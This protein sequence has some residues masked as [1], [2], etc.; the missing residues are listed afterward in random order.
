MVVTGLK[1]TVNVQNVPATV[2]VVSGEQLREQNITHLNDFSRLVSGLQVRRSSNENTW[3]QVRGLGTSTATRVIDT[4]VGQFINDAYMGHNF[5]FQSSLFDMDHMELLKGTQAALLGKNTSLG[6]V[7]VTT[8]EPG[9]DYSSNLTLSHDFEYGSNLADVGVDVPISDTFSVR[10]AGQYNYQGGWIHN[11]IT[12]DEGPEETSTG[13]RITAVWRPNDSFDL[14]FMY[15][16]SRRSRTGTSVENVNDFGAILTGTPRYAGETAGNWQNDASPWFGPETMRVD[17]NVQTLTANYHMN[18]GIKLTSIT[19]HVGATSDWRTD[20]GWIWWPVAGDFEHSREEIWS[21][22]FR[23]TSPDEGRITYQGGLYLARDRY[24]VNT[25]YQGYGNY[26]S[27]VYTQIGGANPPPTTAGTPLSQQLSRVQPTITNDLIDLYHSTTDTAALYGQATY[28]FT[29]QWSVTG[30]LRWTYEKREADFLRQFLIGNPAL[31]PG[32]PGATPAN[33]ST[34]PGCLITGSVPWAFGGQVPSCTVQG[35]SWAG[36][37]NK[38][39]PFRSYYD[40]SISLNYQLND[41]V[42]LYASWSKGTKG[43]NLLSG[44]SGSPSTFFEPEVAYTTELGVKSQFRDLPFGDIR[45]NASIFHVELDKLQVSSFSPGSFTGGN[46]NV[47]S[48][49]V[50]LDVTWRP[51]IN[52]L[53]LGTTLEYVDAQNLNSPNDATPVGNGTPPAGTPE[54]SGY[55]WAEYTQALSDN[56][57]FSILPSVNFRS[58]MY[59]REWVRPG[60]NPCN[61]GATGF[62]N[63]CLFPVGPSYAEINLRL[64]LRND[65]HGWELALV[66]KNLNDEYVLNQVVPGVPGMMVQGASEP[67]RTIALQFSISR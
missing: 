61:P 60:A 54:W 1:R 16:A 10:L 62:T 13:G 25:E 66:G 63:S 40:G 57:S 26:A 56:Y 23:I 14:H 19:A 41:D 12:N 8:R 36:W 2:S 67:G 45:V 38:E 5:Q 49:G 44:V 22:E 20:N 53:T 48:N 39:I 18:S 34:V 11:V 51:P 15:Q 4:S 64:G 9:R 28:N 31:A 65:E 7:V 30:S 47:E 24:D 55:V 52:G 50:D 29:D 32:D 58:E 27:G 37:G 17:G 21:Q 59:L 3:I 6:G 42:L 35:G 46:R 43:A 33:S